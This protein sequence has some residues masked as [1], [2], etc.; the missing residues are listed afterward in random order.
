MLLQDQNMKM[1]VMQGKTFGTEF[2]LIK[3][4]NLES[5]TK[6]NNRFT[7]EVMDA[8]LIGVFKIMIIIKVSE[9]KGSTHPPSKQDI[10]SLK[11]SKVS[12]RL[13]IQV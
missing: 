5:R 12:F 9:Y 3:T 10:L 2:K 6:D 8:M 1:H 13:Q 4:I 11:P 7:F